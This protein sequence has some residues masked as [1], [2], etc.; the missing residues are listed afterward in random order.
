MD[1]NRHKSS[2]LSKAQELGFFYCGFS[3]AGFFRG[4]ST[5]TRKLVEA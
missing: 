1:A 2:I 4:R 3:K 5:K